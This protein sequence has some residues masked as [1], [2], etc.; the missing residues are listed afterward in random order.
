M[1]KT[2]IVWSCAHADPE[3]SNERF[4][5]LSQLIQD[6]K[7]D[8]TIDLGDGADM[9]SLNSYDTR[10]PKAIVSQSYQRDIESYNE[11]QDRL[12]S[13]FRLSKKKRP[14]RIGFEGNHCVPESTE[15]LTAH[16]GWVK[17]SEV[18]VDQMVMTLEGWQVIR[19]VFSREYK[20][21]LYKFATDSTVA[22]VTEG[23]RVYYY[24]TGGKLKVSLAKDMP[25]SADLPV[26]TV[27]GEGVNI[28][29]AQLKFN[30]VALTDSY[31]HKDGKTLTFYQSGDKA[32]EI[33]RIIID[34][35]VPYRKTSR[36]R[37]IKNICGKELK[38][39]QV[40][41][42]FHMKKP[43]WCV[44]SNK[45]LPDWM[46]DLTQEQFDKMLEVLIFCD[47]SIPTRAISSRVFYG[48]KE[49]CDDLQAVLVTKG[50]RASLTEYRTGH[51]RVNLTKTHKSR[52]LKTN[53]GAYG[54]VVW[55]LSVD[56]QNF[57]MR[58][59]NKPV[60]TG[61]CNRLKKAISLDPRLEGDKYGISFSHLQ[62]DHWFD[63]YHEYHNS[64][65]A[66]ADYD[67]V[68]YAH[69]FSAGNFGS[70]MS[71]IHHGYALLQKR[72]SSATCG[73]S[74][75]RSLYFKDD[76]HPNPII[77]LVAGCFKGAE[78]SWAGQANTGWWKGVVIKREISNG[79]YEPQFVSMKEL[80]KA[81]GK[82]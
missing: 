59:D 27:V 82:V 62:T 21:D 67:G 17:I 23:H 40:S 52:A 56:T 36:D 74:H 58:Q 18:M 64:G 25:N 54:G 66:I 46:F 31:H 80:Q 60:F 37:D 20:G 81:Y 3:V 5:W 77:G 15:V 1:T 50:Y 22:Y 32:S 76:A 41:Y 79:F 71:G 42:E 8:Y 63:E 33:E 51:W 19:E 16:A 72:N 10:Y 14:F 11:S 48:R 49:I 38:S 68:S 61:N 47:G 28:S 45:Q 65:P 4:D 2:A 35:G 43:G 24:T 44:E 70:A 69:Y 7:P 78:E 29:D 53:L 34:A 12:W 55:C 26:S 13:P 39:C 75:K 30:A 73:H 9:R 57:L 6:I